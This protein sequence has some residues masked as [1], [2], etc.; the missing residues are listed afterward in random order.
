[1]WA[2][3]TYV[4]DLVD[5]VMEIVERGR[6]ATY[7]VVNSGVCSYYDFARETARVVGLSL[8]EVAKR[9]EPVSMKEMKF[10]ATR[11][12]IRRCRAKRRQDWD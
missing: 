6:F 12:P 7:H 10:S 9:V 11:H 2:N 8:A 1:M 5:R 3:A 4:N